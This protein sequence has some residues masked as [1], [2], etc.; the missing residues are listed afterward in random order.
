[1]DSP[2]PEKIFGNH[3]E[4]QFRLLID[5]LPVIVWT[6]NPNGELDYYNR[7]WE[8]YTGYTVEETKG[9]GWALVLHPDD[10]QSCIDKWTRAITSGEPYEIEYRFKRAADDTYR[11]HLGR[12][13]PFRNEAGTIIKWLGTGIDIEDQVR[14][15]TGDD[16]VPQATHLI[17]VN[18]E[19]TSSLEIKES[20]V[21]TLRS[22]SLRLNEIITT[23]YLLAKAEL[24]IDTFIGLVVEPWRF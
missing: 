6:A 5:T 8:I 15:K 17:A 20:A 2:L 19:F 12:A 7:Q 14:A 1:M 4:P 16:S 18:P 10:L 11:W 24:D 9:W 23:Q 13:V 3:P 21:E 22:D